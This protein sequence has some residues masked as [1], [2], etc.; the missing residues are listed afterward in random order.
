[1]NIHNRRSRLQDQYALQVEIGFVLALALLIVAFRLDFST[2]QNFAVQMQEQEAVQVTEIQQTKQENQPP[3]PPK[4]PVPQEVPNTHVVEQKPPDFDASLDMNER[5]DTSD[6]PPAPANDEGDKE[7][8]EPEVFVVEKYTDYGGLRAL[9]KKLEYLSFPH[10]AGIEGC[11][12][13]QFIV[14]DDGNVTNPT[15]AGGVHKLLN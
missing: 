11:V 5:L 9:Q 12:I 7:E 1:M 13:V 2:D 14:D 4:P 8:Q 15:V 6:P 10:K 3:P